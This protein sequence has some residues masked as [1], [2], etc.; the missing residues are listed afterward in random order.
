MIFLFAHNACAF[1]DETTWNQ[2]AASLC[3]P[4]TL[5]F[6]KCSDGVNLYITSDV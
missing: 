2:K 5:K 1:E 3:R 4:Y 6:T